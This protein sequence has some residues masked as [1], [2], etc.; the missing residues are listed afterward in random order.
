MSAAGQMTSYLGVKG[1][2]KISSAVVKC[3]AS[4]FALTA[5]NYKRQYGQELNSLM[6]VVVQEMVSADS[7]GVMFTCDPA[8]SNPSSIFITANY[9]LGESVV[10]ATADADSYSLR[11][12]GADIVLVA[13]SCGAKDRIVIESDSGDGTEEKALAADRSG[14]FC[15]S[16]EAA[17]GLASIGAALSDATDTPRDI[18]WAIQGGRTFLLQS[19]PVTS[20]LQESDFEIENDY[21]T[22]LYTKREVLTRANFDEVMPGA[23]STLGLSTVF[24]LLLEGTARTRPEFGYTDKSQFTSLQSVIH[25]KKTFMN[26]SQLK[27]LAKNKNMMK[28]LGITSYGYDIREHDAMKNGIFH[29]PGASVKGWSFVRTVLGAIWNIKKNVKE[30]QDSTDRATFDVPEGGDCLSQFMNVLGKVPKMDFFMDG[31]MKT[32]YPSALYNILTLNILKKSQG[33]EDF[34]ADLML[35]LSRLLRSDLEVESAIIADELTTLSNSLRK[36]P[37]ADEFLKMTAEEAVAWLEADQGEAARRF[38]TLRSKH[39]HRCYKELDIHSKT[40]DIDPIPLVETLKSSMRCP[41][42]GDRR[43]AEQSMTVD[44]LPKRPNIMQ[45]KILDYLIPRA[46]YAV[47]ARE[48]AKS[49]VV[50]CIHGLRLAMRQVALRLH[51]EGRLPDPELIFFLSCDEIYRLIK[52]RDPSLLPR[53]RRRQKMHLKLDRE[54]FPVLLYGIPRPIDSSTMTINSDAPCLEGVPVSQGVVRGPARV[55]LDFSTEAQGIARGDILVTRATD[56]GWTPY[57]PLLAGVVTEIGGLLSH[58]AVVAREYGLPAIVG[59]DGATEIIKSGDIVTLDGNQG[60]LY[61]TPPSADD[62]TEGAVEHTAV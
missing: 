55:I 24:K 40:W 41:E 21:N 12:N 13:K 47:Y 22:G 23:F 14:T 34:S 57:F 54:R 11:R 58:G 8:T 61:R 19:R 17:V 42:E 38:R 4:Q 26:F 16:D 60:K 43:K 6:A 36:D 59:L 45:R 51:S 3:W 1:E 50:K 33:L 32:S 49:G 29:G 28:S 27:A 52:N 20:F 37:M 30:I 25:G 46:Q 31:L 53:A 39:A 15:L 10:A 7:A 35:L 56:T 9:G 62:S 18:E 48:A 5:F 2:G 44:E